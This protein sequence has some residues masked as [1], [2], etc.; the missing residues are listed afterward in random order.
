ME[1]SPRFGISILLTRAVEE[2]RRRQCN[3]QPSLGFAKEPTAT[4]RATGSEHAPAFS[5]W[6]SEK[7]QIF[8]RHRGGH[9][10]LT[11]AACPSTGARAFLSE[12]PQPEQR[13]KACSAIVCTY[14]LCQPLFYTGNSLPL[15][16]WPVRYGACVWR[17][18]Y[19]TERSHSWGLRSWCR[20]IDQTPRDGV[21]VFYLACRLLLSPQEKKLV[22]Q[23][24][25]LTV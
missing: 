12:Q 2:S 18:R 24:D 5:M 3:S 10:S 13:S 1:L 11:A 23:G 15:G 7:L 20:C 21:E 19:C 14:S 17:S 8:R 16:G 6:R 9:P 22:R 25:Q 4:H